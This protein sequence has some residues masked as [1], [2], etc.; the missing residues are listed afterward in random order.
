MISLFRRDRLPA[1]LRPVLAPEERVLAWSPVS[2]GGAAIVTNRGLWLSGRRIG[3]HEISKAVWDGRELHVTVAE[4]VD[5]QEHVTV[6][7]DLAPRRVVLERPGDVPHLVRQ[8]VTASIVSS[9]LQE[10]GSRLVARRIPG[11]DGTAWMLHL[12]SD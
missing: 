5:E 2:D 4:V 9:E 3:W 8:R 7:R 1:E 10:D 6:L 11:L 12:P